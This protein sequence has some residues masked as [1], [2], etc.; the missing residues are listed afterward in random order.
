MPTDIALE[1]MR[2]SR[3]RPPCGD[4]TTAL[5]ALYAQI[6]RTELLPMV[7]PKKRT[8]VRS[9]RQRLRETGGKLP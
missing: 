6:Q 4:A 1:R 7:S 8:T 5:I 9:N 2:L 3:R